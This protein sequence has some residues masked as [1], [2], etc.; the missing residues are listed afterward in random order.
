MKSLFVI[1][2]MACL[3]LYSGCNKAQPTAAL[4]PVPTYYSYDGRH[5]VLAF[6]HEDTQALGTAQGDEYV[7]EVLAAPVSMFYRDTDR[8]WNSLGYGFLPEITSVNGHTFLYPADPPQLGSPPEEK[9][10]REIQDGELVDVCRLH[11]LSGELLRRHPG[12]MGYRIGEVFPGT[13]GAQLDLFIIILYENDVERSGT[14]RYRMSANNEV[15]SVD[16]MPRLDVVQETDELLL[17]FS[18]ISWRINRYRKSDPAEQI[19]I[20]AD[21][22]ERIR[23]EQGFEPVSLIENTVILFNRQVGSVWQYDLLTDE[24][25]MLKD[26]SQEQLP[27]S[28]LIFREEVD[29][30]LDNPA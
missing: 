6:L 29:N 7:S 24:K 13:A 18:P 30:P 21:D 8:E 26:I 9:V 20:V 27:N 14:W 11:G 12:A 16:R 28:H 15:I 17:R 5:E 10:I 19:D 1:L 4:H 23:F 3:L 25:T 2:P 22:G